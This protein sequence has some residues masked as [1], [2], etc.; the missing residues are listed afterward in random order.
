MLYVQ[1]AQLTNVKHIHKRK[2]PFSRQ[3]GCYKR[4]L[5]ARVQLQNS[6]VMG[7]NVLGSKTTGLAVN[8]Q[9]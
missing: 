8:R 2:N 9:S 7:L 3:S 6:L 5:A 1:Y 4:T